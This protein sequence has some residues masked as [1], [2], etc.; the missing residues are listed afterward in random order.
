MKTVSEKID[1]I[2]GNHL[3]HVYERLGNVEGKV[4]VILKLVVGICVGVAGSLILQIG[5]LL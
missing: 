5:R 4:S 3:P 2:M 1:E